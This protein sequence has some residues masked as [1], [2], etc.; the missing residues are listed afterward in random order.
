MKYLFVFCC[1]TSVRKFLKMPMLHGT[2]CYSN[3]SRLGTWIC[4]AIEQPQLKSLI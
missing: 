1:L 4:Y 2:A 3:A